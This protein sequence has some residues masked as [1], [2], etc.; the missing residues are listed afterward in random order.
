MTWVLGL[1]GHVTVIK[2]HTVV[3]AMITS[4]DRRAV[5]PSLQSTTDNWQW[6]WS[7]YWLR[8]TIPNRCGSRR[9]GTVADCSSSSLLMHRPPHGLGWWHPCWTTW[10]CLFFRSWSCSQYGSRS[11]GCCL[12][13]QLKLKSVE[14]EQFPAKTVMKWSPKVLEHRRQVFEKYLQVHMCLQIMA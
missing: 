2:S 4:L 1:Q 8:Q 12:F 5:R 14:T 10:S 7:P 11:S 6:W 13:Y 3:N 9:E